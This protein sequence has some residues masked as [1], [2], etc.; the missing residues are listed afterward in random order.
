MTDTNTRAVGLLAFAVVAATLVGTVAIGSAAAQPAPTLQSNE[1][2]TNA[3]N[4]SGP[5]ADMTRAADLA[6]QQPDYVD[7]QV[8]KSLSGDRPV[9]EAAGGQLSISPS[10]PYEDVVD[11]G[12]STDAGS[13][14][15][16][17]E[18]G[19][20][21][22]DS[23]GKEGSFDLYWMVETETDGGNSTERVQ[24]VATVQ[25]T[26]DAQV[27]V[28]DPGQYQSLQEDAQKWEEWNTTLGEIQEDD[29]LLHTLTGT[30][31]KKTIQEG[32]V[33]TYRDSR[34]PGQYVLNS[35]R[36]IVTLLIFSAG[37]YFFL[38]QV[39]GGLL[40]AVRELYGRLN[41]HE[42]NE[43]Y[44]GELAERQAEQHKHDRLQIDAD[45]DY[46]DVPGFTDH[47]AAAFREMATTPLELYSYV[48]GHTPWKKTV[49]DRLRAMSDCGYAAR[50]TLAD[51]DIATDGGDDA[52]L[53][54]LPS[55]DDDT[56]LSD[57]LADGDANAEI[58]ALDD[59]LDTDETID[60]RD[61]LWPIDDP[62]EALVEEVAADPTIW[63]T[64]DLTKADVDAS[65]FDEP[66]ETQS[67][68]HIVEELDPPMEYWDTKEEFGQHLLEVFQF[69]ETQPITDSDGDVR[70]GLFALNRYL[71]LEQYLAD[72]EGVPGARSRSEA[73]ERAL[74]D[75]DPTAE[76]DRFVTEVRQGRA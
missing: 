37:G 12:V 43:K 18:F 46:Q 19:Y 60:D 64:F 70:T 33:D 11:Y 35:Y 59:V 26:D 36:A 20:Y 7:S 22:F 3:T 31:D 38:V 39:F 25:I 45:I 65:S 32:M 40:P 57:L 5:D 74:I 47:D 10:V 14:S 23:E 4:T 63:R 41:R 6:I 48:R 76:T 16:N 66:L 75:Y 17:P 28:V 58:V 72:V 55:G 68:K 67:L 21:T 8:A 15:Y 9:Y 29:L 61:E 24:H 69:L 71:Q 30:P 56:D 73:I 42:E 49:R 51:D 54:A 2:T 13:L 44:E 1:S 27:Q 62:S 50:V 34:D 53:P 52:D